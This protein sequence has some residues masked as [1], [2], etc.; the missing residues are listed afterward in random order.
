MSDPERQTT[1][2][3]TLKRDARGIP[4]REMCPNVPLPPVFQALRDAFD[5][6]VDQLLQNALADAKEAVACLERGDAL[7]ADILLKLA[8]DQLAQTGLIP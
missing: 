4:Y 1:P 6:M 8:T 5:G 7:R 3:P 2:D